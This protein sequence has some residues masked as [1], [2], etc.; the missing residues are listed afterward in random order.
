MTEPTMG[1]QRTGEQPPCPLCGSTATWH[2]CLGAELPAADQSAERIDLAA[3]VA[4]IRD[5]MAGVQARFERVMQDVRQLP[6][7]DWLYQR[8]DAYPGIRL[9]RDMG[10]GQDAD[11][12]LAEVAA[13]LEGDE[14]GD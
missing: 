11:G 13:F 2:R 7:G 14:P 3:E 8:V 5:E 9:D 6:G 1:H 12:W 4:E 10:A